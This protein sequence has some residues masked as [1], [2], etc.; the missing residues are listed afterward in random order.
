MST[1]DVNEPFKI[2]ADAWVC[3]TL[4]AA[5]DFFLKNSDGHCWLKAAG[6]YPQGDLVKSCSSYPEA[7]AFFGKPLEGT[8]VSN[9]NAMDFSQALK[10][11]KRGC[12]MF[13]NGWNGKHTL[14]LPRIPDDIDERSVVR[15][16]V[17][18][19]AQGD[20]VA[21]TPSVT[22]LLAEDWEAQDMT[23]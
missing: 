14:E 22:D 5:R 11:L 18:H 4:E 1:S 15:V 7:E 23:N 6:V 3:H 10:E 17:L 21:W 16:F 9:P 2:P 19:T 12:V 20:A 13:R 8:E